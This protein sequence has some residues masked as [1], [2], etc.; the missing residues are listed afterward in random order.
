MACDRVKRLGFAFVTCRRTRI[1]N[2]LR[3]LAQ[4][5]GHISREFEFNQRCTQYKIGSK[6][7]GGRAGLHS[8]GF[9]HP[10]LQAAV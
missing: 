10:G 7:F 4:V 8:A 6:R 1:H 2:G 9:S 5:A 3:R